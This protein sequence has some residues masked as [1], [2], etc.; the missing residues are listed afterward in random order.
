MSA[1]T[2]GELFAVHLAIREHIHTLACAQ[3]K[4]ITDFKSSKECDVLYCIKLKQIVFSNVNFD[5]DEHCADNLH[6]VKT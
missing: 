4:S 6:L 2:A 5:D 3:P 1:R